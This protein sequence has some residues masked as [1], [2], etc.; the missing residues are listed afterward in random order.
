MVSVNFA[1]C[2]DFV[3]AI[4]FQEIAETLLGQSADVLGSMYSDE[5]D[6][7]DGI[8]KEAVF[9]NYIAKFR[10]KIETYNVR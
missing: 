8:I 4:C 9:K 3:W 6:V 10:A 1:D 2:S 7:F 5:V